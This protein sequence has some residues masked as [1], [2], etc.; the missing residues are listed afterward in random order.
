MRLGWRHAQPLWAWMNRGRPAPIEP[1]CDY[2]KGAQNRRASWPLKRV[3]TMDE[4]IV[5]QIFDELLSSLEP[6]ETQNTALLQFLR[7]KGIASDNELAPFLEQAGNAS[8]VRW[9]AMRVRIAAL[10]ASAMKPTEE[11]S[12]GKSKDGQATP[13]S[14]AETNEDGREKEELDSVSVQDSQAGSFSKANSAGVQAQEK[15]ESA[16]ESQTEKAEVGEKENAA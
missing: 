1:A 14:T 2:A 6:L 5:K 12:T 3:T 13:E 15:S 10:I 16:N 4:Q 8:N 7:A 11:V 9:R